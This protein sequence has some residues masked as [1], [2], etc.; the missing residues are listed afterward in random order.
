MSPQRLE[1][2]R[3]YRSLLVSVFFGLIRADNTVEVAFDLLLEHRL[4]SER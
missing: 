4:Q 2:P 1:G 3:S